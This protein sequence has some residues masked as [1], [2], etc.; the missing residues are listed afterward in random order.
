VC[1]PAASERAADSNRRLVPSALHSAAQ[2][3]AATDKTLLLVARPDQPIRILAVN[4]TFWPE[5][6]AALAA[7]RALGMR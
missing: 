2:R 6:P 3:L 7:G 5:D 1:W 4:A